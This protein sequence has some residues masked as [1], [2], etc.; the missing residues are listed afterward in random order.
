HRVNRVAPLGTAVI[1]HDEG[2]RRFGQGHRGDGLVDPGSHSVERIALVRRMPVVEAVAFHAGEESH[3]LIPRL[4]ALSHVHSTPRWHSRKTTERRA[5]R[6]RG[7]SILPDWADLAQG[8]ARRSTLFSYP[9]RTSQLAA[10]GL[11]GSGASLI[12]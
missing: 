6:D 7:F 12:I 1:G 4:V 8:G 5:G 10:F 9:S 2:Q 11:K 3:G